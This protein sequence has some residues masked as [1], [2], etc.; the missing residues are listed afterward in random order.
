MTAMIALFLTTITAWLSFRFFESLSWS[1]RNAGRLHAS[2]P[3]LHNGLP[4]HL[5]LSNTSSTP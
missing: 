2:P 5:A 3:S 4:S 1:S